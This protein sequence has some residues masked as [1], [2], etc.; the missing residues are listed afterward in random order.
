[1]AAAKGNKAKGRRSARH[2]GKYE[3]QRFRTAANKARQATARVRRKEKGLKKKAERATG[4]A[5]DQF[6]NPHVKHRAMRRTVRRILKLVPATLNCI[7]G[8]VF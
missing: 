7:A 2:K 8:R 3:Q 4:Y 5:S 1:M 6:V